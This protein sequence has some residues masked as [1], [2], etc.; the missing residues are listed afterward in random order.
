MSEVITHS[1]PELAS[2]DVP[3]GAWGRERQAFEAL[4]PTLLATLRGQYVAIHDGMVVASGSDRAVVAQAAYARVGYV[5]VYLGFLNES[6][7]RPL[8]LP[9]PRVVQDGGSS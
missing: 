2:G 6:L 4:L 8:R 5:P 7:P 1:P 3:Q 9:S